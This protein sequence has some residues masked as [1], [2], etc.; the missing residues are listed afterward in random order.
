MRSDA[1]VV[2]E[3]LVAIDIE[4]YVTDQASFLQV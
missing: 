3:H 2:V 1:H 4:G